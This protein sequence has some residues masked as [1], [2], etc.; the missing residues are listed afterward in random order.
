MEK[1]KKYNNVVGI[2]RL[3]QNDG[4]PASIITAT[5]IMVLHEPNVNTTKN[6]RVV[7]SFNANLALND[8]TKSRLSYAMNGMTINETQYGT[9]VRVT[10]FMNPGARFDQLSNQLIK[11]AKIT[12]VQGELKPRSYHDDDGA[13]VSYLELLVDPFNIGFINKP[14]EKTRSNS[15]ANVSSASSAA[16]NDLTISEEDLPF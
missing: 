11:G 6:G 7:M 10:I 16:G 3:Q 2:T 9:T 14:G 4:S 15:D 13:L 5:N 12:L 1:E 8:F